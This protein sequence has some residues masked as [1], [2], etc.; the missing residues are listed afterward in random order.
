[1]RPHLSDPIDSWRS[2]NS[3]PKKNAA[4]LCGFDMK[5]EVP[6]RLLK[7]MPRCGWTR[8]QRLKHA[9]CK[10]TQQRR[11]THAGKQEQSILLPS[12]RP[13]DPLTRIF[14][15]REE[16]NASHAPTLQTR[17]LLRRQNWRRS[18]HRAERSV[19]LGRQAE[20]VVPMSHPDACLWL[21]VTLRTRRLHLPR[22]HSRAL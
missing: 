13:S 16:P 3:R 22:Q 21:R 9:G 15:V 14:H 17:R 6:Q 11:G 5:K 7:P 20:S 19:V 2:T 4:T 12:P 8:R 18:T 1:M 10:E